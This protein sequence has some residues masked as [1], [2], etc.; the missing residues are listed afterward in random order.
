M[1]LNSPTDIPSINDPKALTRNTFTETLR[2][3]KLT[4]NLKKLRS[5]KFTFCNE[6][7]GK[8][9]LAKEIAYKTNF[10]L[11]LNIQPN[12]S[13]HQF[14]FAQEISHGNEYYQSSVVY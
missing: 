2:R 7:K 4:C 13:Q 14:S 3:K 1:K 9:N 5:R 8:R 10:A 11:Y 6:K 12:T